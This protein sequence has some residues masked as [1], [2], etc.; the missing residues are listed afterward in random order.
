MDKQQEAAI[1][2]AL[3]NGKT[4]LI[5]E[6]EAAESRLLAEAAVREAFGDQSGADS[7]RSYVDDGKQITDRY[8]NS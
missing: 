7:L 3:E 2:E 5:Q 6:R 8:R 4:A 1:R